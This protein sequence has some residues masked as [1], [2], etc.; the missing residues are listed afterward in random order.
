MKKFVLVIASCAIAMAIV[1]PGCAGGTTSQQES[2]SSTN[3]TETTPL[4]GGWAVN[5]GAS[6][7]TA[8]EQAAYD[9][10]VEGTEYAGY[11]AVAVMGTQVVA[12]TNYAVLCYDG[13]DAETNG[14]S[15]Y[16]GVVYADLEG[17]AQITSMKPF[18]L[19]SYI[20]D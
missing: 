4:A 7:L 9:K 6:A 12:G 19:M 8:D 2:N 10:A 15:W 20:G 18:D 17:N 3:A 5:E 16:I 1:L 13:G 11:K 14:G